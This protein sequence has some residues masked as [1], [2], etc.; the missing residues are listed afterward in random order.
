MKELITLL[1]KDG[2]KSAYSLIQTFALYLTALIF[3]LLLVAYIVVKLRAKEKLASFK[4]IALGITIGYA[5]TLCAII[6][7]LMVARINLK[8]ELDKNYFLVLGFLVLLILYSLALLITSLSSK[9]A[10]KITNLIG[11]SLIGIY[12]ILL[13]ILLP[14]IDK[15]YQPL[16]TFGMYG[17]SFVLVAIILVLTFAFGK[18]N[19]TATQ[20]KTIAYAGVCISLSYALS[21][22]KFFT[23]GQ[24]GGSVTL[25]SLLP[26]MIFSYCFGVKKGLFAGVI[27]GILQFIQ[28]P[29]VY[30]P[31]QVLLDYPIAFGAI[32]LAGLF[33]NASK[34]KNPTLKFVLGATL[35]VTL[36]Y[37]AHLLSGYYVFS[38]WAWPGY[39]AFAYSAIYNLYCFVDLAVILVPAVALFASKSFLSQL[40]SINK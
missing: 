2:L 25:A 24:N 17:F 26:L 11:L 20:T 14:T 13:L 40:D 38:S 4:L 34:I 21:F 32:G 16:N 37:I 30:Q 5:V 31:M 39:G 27:Y 15:D 7:F 33:A 22:V 23:V 12:T 1:G 6:L 19:G 10:L 29:Q 3:V 8:A 35:A 18:N 36:R 9:K 28:S